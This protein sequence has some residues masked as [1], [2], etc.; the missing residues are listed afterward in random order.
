MFK[1]KKL[2]TALVILFVIASN[3]NA[4]DYEYDVSGQSDNGYIYGEIE[5]ERG[6]RNVE[7]YLYDENGNEVYF[8]GEWSGKGEIEGY[9]ENGNYIE[10]DVD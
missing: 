8:E 5:A 6:S 7:G 3:A 4:A 1:L 9:D 10:L 2:V